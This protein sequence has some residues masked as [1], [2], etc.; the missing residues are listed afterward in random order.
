MSAENQKYDQ[1]RAQE[2]VAGLKRLRHYVT[3]KQKANINVAITFLE[4]T[5]LMLDIL[6]GKPRALVRAWEEGRRLEKAREEEVQR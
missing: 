4:K 3:R 2:C 6:E 5:V 1:A